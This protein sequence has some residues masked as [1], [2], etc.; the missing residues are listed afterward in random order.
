MPERPADRLRERARRPPPLGDRRL[1]RSAG[2]AP[3]ADERAQ[4]RARTQP[5]PAHARTGRGTGE[6]LYAGL[7]DLP[8]LGDLRT[9]RRPDLPVRRAARAR[10]RA[11]AGAL[12]REVR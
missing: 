8:A 6:I 10:T 9:G 7:D 12:A 5:L 4:R 2:A 3:A 1:P 11:A